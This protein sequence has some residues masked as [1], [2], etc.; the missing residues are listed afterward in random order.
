MADWMIQNRDFALRCPAPEVNKQGAPGHVNIPPR[1][2][3]AV[4]MSEGGT[5]TGLLLLP[6]MPERELPLNRS[7]GASAPVTWCNPYDDAMA[8]GSGK[9]G[10][11]TS[12]ELY[13]TGRDIPVR[14]GVNV[15][16]SVYVGAQDVDSVRSV[17]SKADSF[18][19]AD[20]GNTP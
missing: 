13:D 1:R 7:R 5:T 12:V 16:G 10:K 17:Q 4:A 11:F 19:S 8:P 3:R 14:D 15:E 2:M 20:S 18:F 9:T 6:Q